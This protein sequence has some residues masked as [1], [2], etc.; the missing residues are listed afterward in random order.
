MRLYSMSQKRPLS[1]HLMIYKPQL[2]S[3][4]SITHRITGAFLVAGSLLL[5]CWVIAMAMGAEYFACVQSLAGSLIGQIVLFGFSIAVYYH[6]L[7]GIRHLLWDFG[8]NLSIEGVARTG[9]IVMALTAVLT[10][11]TWAMVI[12]S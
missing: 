2:T 9:Y 6:S 3:V 10:I 1:P 8:Y 12:M 5:V 7:N 11:V 4:M